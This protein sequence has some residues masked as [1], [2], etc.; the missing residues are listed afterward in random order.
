MNAPPGMNFY[1]GFDPADLC[2][3]YGSPLY[4]YDAEVILRQLETFRTAFAE[5]PHRV[6]YLS[7]IH[8]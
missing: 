6:L 3:T 1:S 5:L 2:E 8:I 4:V 7:L